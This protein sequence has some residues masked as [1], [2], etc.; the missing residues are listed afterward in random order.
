MR[1]RGI[2]L[3]ASFALFFFKH[4]KREKKHP[5]IALKNPSHSMIFEKI[6]EKCRISIIII[7][8]LSGQARK[9]IAKM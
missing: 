6:Q 3:G 4:E 7:S 2:F 8:I 1:G 5:T 9:T